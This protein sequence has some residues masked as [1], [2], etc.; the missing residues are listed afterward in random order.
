MRGRWQAFR[1]ARARRQHDEIMGDVWDPTLRQIRG[2]TIEELHERL[3]KEKLPPVALSMAQS[4]LRR[5]EAWSAPAAR[6]L[7]AS[8]FA[9][10]IS[11]LAL[12]LPV[13]KQWIWD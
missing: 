8:Y 6:S 5:R 12:A 7:R 9:I 2:W 3:I 1:E 13:L 11:I 10:A 4:E